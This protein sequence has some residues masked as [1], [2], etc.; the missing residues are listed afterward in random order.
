MPD[1][2][3][4]VVGVDELIDF[5]ERC[6]G[7][8]RGHNDTRN[9]VLHI[10]LSPITFQDAGRRRRTRAYSI[11]GVDMSVDF[12]GESMGAKTR[13]IEGGVL[14]GGIRAGGGGLI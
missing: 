12:M 4:V 6:R 1:L 11:V 5:I 7:C 13:L 3:G 9:K 10:Y 8:P 2:N 14:G